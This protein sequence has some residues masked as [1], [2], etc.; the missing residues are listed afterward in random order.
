MEGLGVTDRCLAG[1]LFSLC[2]LGQWPD[3]LHE[4]RLVTSSTDTRIDS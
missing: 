4:G 1:M 3:A 2:S